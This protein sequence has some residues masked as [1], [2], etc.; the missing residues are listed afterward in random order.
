MTDA[1]S[2]RVVAE[3]ATTT[4]LVHIGGRGPQEWWRSCVVFVNDPPLLDVRSTAADVTERTELLRPIS[5]LGATAVRIGCPG[6]DDPVIDAAVEELLTRARRLGV[7]VIM[8][9]DPLDPA[10]EAPARHWLSR[11]V[12]G[13]DLG[14]VGPGIPE[15]SHERYRELQALLAEHTD[16]GILSARLSPDAQPQLSEM[17]HEDWLHHVVDAALTRTQT[18][19]AV[20]DA[21]DDAY[22]IRDV[23]G[24]PAA[25]LVPDIADTGSLR[26]ARA[27]ALLTL[28]LPGALYLR[29]GTALG[30]PSRRATGS[31]AEREA[32]ADAARAA[33]RG[34][35]GSTYEMFRAALRLRADY[36]LGTAPLAWVHGLPAAAEPQTV[37]FLSGEVLV[38]CN[39]GAATLRLPAGSDIL[40]TSAELLTADDGSFLVPPETTVWIW[41]ASPGSERA[42]RV[43]Q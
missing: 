23:L 16:D 11:G 19:A 5:R 33:Q 20:R 41:M 39:F 25:W 30:L 18:V 29:Q 36:R 37:A 2:A 9:I 42:E 17:L 40:H 38:L 1:P 26:R 24:A 4:T 7:R 10:H 28:A 12:D 8:R 6:P 21:I 3:P 34:V 15:V 22:A 14:P 43:R 27:G 35:T 32:E 31:L 13:L